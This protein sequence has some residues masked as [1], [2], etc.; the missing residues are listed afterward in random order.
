MA[1]RVAAEDERI[2]AEEE[3]VD[4]NDERVSGVDRMHRDNTSIHWPRTTWTTC[5]RQAG[6]DGPESTVAADGVED[7]AVD[8]Q[9]H[10]SH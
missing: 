5:T 8:E 10:L 9:M 2:D 4:A 7:E 3:R 6:R 1:E